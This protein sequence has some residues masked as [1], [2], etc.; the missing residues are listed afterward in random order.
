MIFCRTGTLTLIIKALINQHTWSDE[1]HRFIQSADSSFGD[2]SQDFKIVSC[3]SQYNN[4]CNFSAWHGG[5][6]SPALSGFGFGR[7]NHSNSSCTAFCIFFAVLRLASWS[8]QARSTLPKSVS[9]WLVGLALLIFFFQLIIWLLDGSEVT[10]KAS[11]RLSWT[12]AKDPSAGRIPFANIWD[13]AFVRKSS[14][15]TVEAFTWEFLW[16]LH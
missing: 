16:I 2:M 13:Q 12:C 15:K 11:I 3:L 5:G 9:M 14:A 10:L 8:K 1:T 4:V 7:E 6:C